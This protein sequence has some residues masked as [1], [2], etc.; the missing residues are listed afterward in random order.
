MRDSILT[1]KLPLNQ[2][3]DRLN[4]DVDR[5]IGYFVVGFFVLGLLL[6]PFYN[7]WIFG[8]GIGSLNLLL[9]LVASSWISSPL[10]RRQVISL[11][12]SI[13]MLQFIGQMHGMYEMHF[14]YF[15]NIAILIIYQ[16]WRVMIP[17][18]IFAIGHHS[19]FFYF[20]INGYGDFREYFINIDNIGYTV[21]FFHFGLAIIMAIICGW[22]AKILQASSAEKAENLRLLMVQNEQLQDSEEELSVINN[23][24]ILQQN[25]LEDAV[26][27]LKEKNFE[28]DQIVYK[29]SHDLRSPLTSIQGIVQLIRMEP[30]KLEEYLAYIESRTRKLDAF[31]VS[32]LDYGKAS[33][34][35]GVFQ[36][37]DFDKLIRDCLSDLQFKPKFE[38]INVQISVDAKEQK[39]AF[40]SDIFR[41]KIILANLISNAIKYQNLHQDESMLHIRITVSD[42][43]AQLKFID[44]GIGIGQKYLDKVFEMF[45]R[46]TEDNEGSGL[47]LYIV[48]QCVDK[49]GG[50]IKVISKLGEGTTFFFTLANMNE[51]E[52]LVMESEKLNYE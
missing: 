4:Q 37:V 6:I 3:F 14:F 26:K 21:L 49:L 44:N 35:E 41:L 5:V 47:G 43:E 23:E 36:K 38:R 29:T 40:V 51:R 2:Y 8:L 24:L 52:G 22:W 33:R 1:T 18:A 39:K 27:N 50:E 7:T 34:A 11:I 30:E 20:Q 42:Y 9:Y 13:F 45:S 19:V 10:I 48:K 25:A 17:Y 15:I 16:D 12:F 31:V 32:M 28:L 46:A